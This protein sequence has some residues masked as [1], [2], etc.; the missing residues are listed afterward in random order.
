MT[1]DK[2]KIK[3]LELMVSEAHNITLCTHTSPD[4]DTIG[5][6]LALRNVLLQ[7]NKNVKVVFFVKVHFFIYFI[8]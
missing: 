6:A 1:L 4:A 3:Q 2:N 7:M 5:S 8:I